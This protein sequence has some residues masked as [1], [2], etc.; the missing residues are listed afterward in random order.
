M[1][2]GGVG[3]V[4]LDERTCSYWYSTPVR[5]EVP[6]RGLRAESP[7]LAL[8]PAASGGVIS[9]LFPPTME[10]WAMQSD[11]GKTAGI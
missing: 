11:V 5:E 3:V 1:G 4:A 10:G 9:F 2:S 6:L 8:V 7:A